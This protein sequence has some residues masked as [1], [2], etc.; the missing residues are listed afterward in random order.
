[1]QVQAVRQIDMKKCSKCETYF[2]HYIIKNNICP[3]CVDSV[4]EQA[5]TEKET[6]NKNEGSN[7][8]NM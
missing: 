8:N 4:L 3:N 1:M 7:S 2:A 5:V 6:P